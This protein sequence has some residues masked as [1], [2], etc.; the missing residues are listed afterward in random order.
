MA[1]G[2]GVKVGIDG[3]KEFKQ[4]ISNINS[5]LK[6]MTSELRLLLNTG[7]HHVG[8]AAVR[9]PRKYRLQC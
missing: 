1:K 6:T 8:P 4:S 5:T 7:Y 3:E 2:I 9:Y